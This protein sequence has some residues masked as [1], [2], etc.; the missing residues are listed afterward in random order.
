MIIQGKDLSRLIF[1]ALVK[2]RAQSIQ[3][4]NCKDGVYS[5]EYEAGEQTGV[6]NP[7]GWLT[8]NKVSKFLKLAGCYSQSRIAGALETT[9][10]KVSRLCWA[11]GIGV[12]KKAVRNE[13]EP[14]FL[15]LDPEEQLYYL[16][17]LDRLINRV[18][19]A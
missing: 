12:D 16:S 7:Y 18:F 5:I 8:I 4:I 11:T 1:K 6:V 2:Q 17:D 3:S 14:S 13:S 10:Y 9:A 15:A 19:T